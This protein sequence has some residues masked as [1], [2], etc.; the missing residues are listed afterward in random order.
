MEAAELKPYFS[1]IIISEHTGYKKPD[2]GIF[3]FAEKQA[4]CSPEQCLMIGD[5]LEV[6]VIGAQDA[7]W[8]AIYFNPGSKP[9]DAR[10]TF[11]I[12]GLDELQQLL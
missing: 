11:E 12:R 1:E 9:H 6:D 5:G 7:G 2:T 4:S 10:P 3:R 8:D